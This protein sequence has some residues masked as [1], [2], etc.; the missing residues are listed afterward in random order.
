MGISYDELLPEKTVVLGRCYIGDRKFLSGTESR[1]IS[2]DGLQESSVYK[3]VERL[4]GNTLGQFLQNDEIQ[5]AVPVSPVR[6]RD[7]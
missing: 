4:A 5:V 2:P 7:G 3:S 6:L 1:V